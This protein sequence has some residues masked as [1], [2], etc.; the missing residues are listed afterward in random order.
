MAEGYAQQLQNLP[1]RI[2]MIISQTC[3]EAGD[4]FEVADDEALGKIRD[5]LLELDQEIIERAKKRRASWKGNTPS[6][7]KER[8][9]RAKT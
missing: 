7:K 5:L 6:R 3:A 8:L 9:A 1:N 2:A 4:A